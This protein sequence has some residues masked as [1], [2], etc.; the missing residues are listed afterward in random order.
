MPEFTAAEAQPLRE[1]HDGRESSVCDV[2]DV[3]RHSTANEALS[4]GTS[5]QGQR[6]KMTPSVTSKVLKTIAIDAAYFG[7]VSQRMLSAEW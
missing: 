4:G 7:A 6:H 1:R 3:N 2:T 5:S